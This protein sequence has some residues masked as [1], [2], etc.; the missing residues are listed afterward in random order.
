MPVKIGWRP[1]KKLNSLEVVRDSRTAEIMDF[2]CL[3]IN[4]IMARIFNQEP[5]DLIGQ[6]VFKR[7]IYKNNP[8]LLSKFLELV[9]TGKY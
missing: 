9:E 4:P 8:N 6:L 2:R 7:F 5:E 1:N 3:V